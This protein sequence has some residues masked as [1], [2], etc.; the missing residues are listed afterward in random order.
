MK[1]AIVGAGSA[2]IFAAYRLANIEKVTVDLFEKG[3]SIENR[4]RNEVMSGFGG[5]GAFS[6]G[7]LT[8]TTE[9]G[10]WL[11]DFLM[12]RA[13]PILLMRPMTSGKSFQVYMS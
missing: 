6:D 11:T 8:L 12:K 5:A 10:G 3:N 13:F 9:F 4:T 7:K 1:V 2:G